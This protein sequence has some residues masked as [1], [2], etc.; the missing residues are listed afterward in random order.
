MQ[1]LDSHS[2]LITGSSPFPTMRRTLLFPRQRSI[3]IYC[4]S[5]SKG[6]CSHVFGGRFIGDFLWF[7]TR[8]PKQLPYAVKHTLSSCWRWMC[9]SIPCV[10]TQPRPDYK[11]RELSALLVYRLSSTVSRGAGCKTWVCPCFIPF[12]VCT[13]RLWPHILH[14]YSNRRQVCPRVNISP[15]YDVPE[16]MSWFGIQEFSFLLSQRQQGSA[17]PM[18]WAERYENITDIH[19]Q[20]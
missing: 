5:I 8:P 6:A 9:C 17:V 18:I 14:M 1:M 19:R 10:P 15:I 13:Y 4:V 2:R 3:H 11:P 20:R 7:I 16:L 12:H